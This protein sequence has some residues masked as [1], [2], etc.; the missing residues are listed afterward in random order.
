MS[1]QNLR[2]SKIDWCI[3]IR[4]V[5]WLD[6]E[7]PK[8]FW[9]SEGLPLWVHRDPKLLDFG[10]FGGPSI[11]KG[12]G[13]Q[14]PK[15]FWEL[16]IKSIDPPNKDTSINFTPSQILEGQYVLVS[17]SSLYKL[18]YSIGETLTFISGK[19]LRLEVTPALYCLTRWHNGLGG[20]LWS[21]TL[22]VRSLSEA[23][24]FL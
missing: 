4:R 8:I 12:G 5:Y 9:G 7:L 10:S 21:R 2:R 20:R 6:K 1:L 22:R 13:S 15:N 18:I 16:F 3:F 11:C 14:T 17:F 24:F 19:C 23:I